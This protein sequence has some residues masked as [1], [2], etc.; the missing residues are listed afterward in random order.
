MQ[1]YGIFSRCA[2][3]AFM[4]NFRPYGNFEKRAGLPERSHSHAFALWSWFHAHC[5]PGSLWFVIGFFLAVT[6]GAV[7]EWRRGRQSCHGPKLLPAFVLMAA[8]MAVTEFAVVVITDGESDIEKHL[9]LF[10]LFSDVCLVAA[11]MWIAK[12]VA[13]AW[14]QTALHY[15]SRRLHPAGT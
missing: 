4:L 3:R 7:Y 1:L 2:K 10:N 5:M 14:R 6:T 9:V 15:Q 12:W 13:A 8:A 11:V